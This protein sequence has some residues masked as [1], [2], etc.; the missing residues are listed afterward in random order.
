MIRINNPL[1]YIILCN[2]TQI[3]RRIG[4]KYFFFILIQKIDIY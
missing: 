1:N 4:N 3:L 2:I